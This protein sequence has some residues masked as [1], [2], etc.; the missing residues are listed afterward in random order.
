MNRRSFKRCALALGFALPIF[1]G[2]QQEA[3]DEDDVG[4][5]TTLVPR[6]AVFAPH[7]ADA[8]LLGLARFSSGADSGWIAVGGH[9]D[10]LRSTDGKRW[11]QMA[12]PVDTTLNRVRFFDGHGWAVGYD[13]AVLSSDDGGAHWQLA[14]F[15]AAWG[16]PWFD[17]LFLDDTHGFLAGAN[18]NLKKTEDGGK[19]W[20]AVESEVLAD[21]P[22]LYNLIALGDGSL[23]IAGERGFLA[24]SRD[25]GASW[26]QLKSPYTGSYFGALA[27]GGPGAAPGALVF[28]LRGNAFYAADIG[29]SAPLTAKELAALRTAAGDA[30]NATRNSS[31]V[32]QVAGWVH[33]ANEDTEPLFGGAVDAGGQAVLVGQNG[34]VMQADLAGGRLTRLSIASDINMNAVTAESGA[35]IVVGTSGAKRV[36]L[37]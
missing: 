29:K 15:D 2:A 10:V 7:A 8:L 5:D 23:L 19:T 22:N 34:R 9:G 16:K 3:A 11:Q 31:P 35:L 13:G 6:P 25:R 36:T 1:A 20:T 14:Q 18:G 28:G 4:K 30:E 17:V 32:S 24:R 37:R 33:L 27:L 26:Q 12:S 21:Q